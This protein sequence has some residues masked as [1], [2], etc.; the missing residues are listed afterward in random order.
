MNAYKNSQ[1]LMN[2]HEVADY[3]RLRER[4]IYELVA[5][6]AI[7]HSRVSGKLLF[8]R[9]LVDE[10]VNR[11]MAGQLLTTSRNAPSVVAGS[12]D[13]LLEWAIRESRCGLATLTYGSSDGID[14]LIGGQA[15]AAALHLPSGNK[16]MAQSRLAHLDC[17]MV[18]WATREQGLVI[19]PK[20]PKKIKGIADLK[21]AKV[22]TIVRQAGAGSALLFEKLLAN[23]NIELSELHL[24]IP[25]APSE[26][27]VATAILDGRADAG[28]AVRAVAQQFHLDF[29]PLATEELDIALLRGSYFDPPLQRLFEFTRTALF[30]RHAK[31]LAG[32]DIKSIGQVQWNA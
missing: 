3:L 5:Q 17:V 32:Y 12:S 6:R 11:G 22:K 8:P 29:I 7:P 27:D 31:L 2:T 25:A 21:K 19:A 10:W 28:L 4:K 30:Q 9:A 15:C 18:R 13:P 16:E 20:N 26:S 23:A 1:S 24:I 14:R